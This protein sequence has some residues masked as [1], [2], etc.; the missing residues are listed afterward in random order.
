M[1]RKHVEGPVCI[2]YLI[3][4]RDDQVRYIGKSKDCA[5]RLRK[6]ISYAT[7][8]S[9]R[10]SRKWIW[11]LKKIGLVPAM[12]VVETCPGDGCEE[13]IR[14]IR[15][16]REQGW[17]LTNMTM[18]GEGVLG[19]KCPDYLREKMSRDRKGKPMSPAAKISHAA[20]M[21]RLRG[22]IKHDP[23]SVRRRA[24]KLRGRPMHPAVLAAVIAANRGRK[25]DPEVVKRRADMLRGR[26]RSP[27]AVAKTAA[28]RRGKLHTAKSRALMSQNRLGKNRVPKSEATRQR[29]KAAQEVKHGPL[30]ERSNLYAGIVR[31][32]ERAGIRI[33]KVWGAA[34]FHPTACY[35]VR[36]STPSLATIG[37]L[38]RALD[39][40]SATHHLDTIP[41]NLFVYSPMPL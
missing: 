32:A 9:R 10:N 31:D 39:A 2:Y 5:D 27:E 37:E 18:G 38:R 28:G 6:H 12:R 26:K 8:R 40:M 16:A 22:H 34:G 36:K 19:W 23:E 13:E 11:S 24:D 17:K 1:G 14:H 4:P 33:T 30:V 15:E 25:Q 35:N 29:M 41:E 21:A 7:A 3:D 20:A